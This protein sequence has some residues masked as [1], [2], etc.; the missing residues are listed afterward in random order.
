MCSSEQSAVG[1]ACILY[2]S[3]SITLEIGVA[4]LKPVTAIQHGRHRENSETVRQR[5][6]QEKL[7]VSNGIDKSVF[8]TAA[9]EK[10]EHNHQPHRLSR[11][12]R[13]HMVARQHAAAT[14]TGGADCPY[15]IHRLADPD[16]SVRGRHS[17]WRLFATDPPIA[18]GA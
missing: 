2:L 7:S 4:C 12:L 11:R 16:Y 8:N 3:F 9:K 6:D 5:L 13:T 18:S 1:L 17:S 10:N 14:G 15:S